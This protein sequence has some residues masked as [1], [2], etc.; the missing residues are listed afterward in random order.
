MPAFKPMTLRR[1]FAALCFLALSGITLCNAADQKPTSHGG[2]KAI[3]SGGLGTGAAIDAQGRLWIAVTETTPTGEFVVLQMSADAG[4][5]WSAAKRIQSEPEAVSADGENRPKLAFGPDGEVYVSYTR[6]LAK[7]YTGEIRFVRS[8]DGGKTFLPPITV[9]ANRDL[10]THRFDSMIVDHTG[11]I[12]IAWIDK[13]DLEAA[14]SRNES[15]TGAALYYAVSEDRG[16]NFKGD[17]KIADHTCECCRIAMT[18]NP[19]GTPVALWRHVYEPNI[20][21]H[22]LVKLTPTG[23]MPTPVR[24]TF[25]EWRI[26]A[27]PHQGPSLTYAADGTRHQVWFS[28]R[29][30]EGGVFYAATDPSGALKAPIQ[31]GSAQAASGD[32]AIEG[33]HIVVAWKQFDGKSTSVLGKVS[34]DGGLTWQGKEF[35]QTQGNSD[36]P[37]LLTMP[38]GIMLVW[39]THDEGVRVISPYAGG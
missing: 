35:A 36:H 12:Y 22:A 18:L 11:R 17:Y 19:A 33:D 24:A 29:G 21:D 7:P 26:D 6:P 16:A 1:R 9:H 23:K 5:T 25:D 4:K 37:R 38:A 28:V 34:G 8:L 20:R 10:I 27:C 32:V 13:R 14:V 2:M 3:K 15:Y 30:E 39:R 31:L